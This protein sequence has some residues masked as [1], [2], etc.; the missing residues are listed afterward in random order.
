MLVFLFEY[1][2]IFTC[3][4]RRFVEQSINARPKAR[5]G[6]TDGFINSKPVEPGRAKSCG[7]TTPAALHGLVRR[8]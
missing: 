2:G 3:G 7:T 6:M 8:S 1:F 4:S 5:L